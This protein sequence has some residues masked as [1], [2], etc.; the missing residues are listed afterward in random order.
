MSKK[1]YFGGSIITMDQSNPDVQ[2]L[3]VAEGRIVALGSLD[4]CRDALGSGYDEVDLQGRALLPGFFDVHIHPLMAIVFE[5]NVNLHGARDL[6]ELK[7]RFADADGEWLVGLNFDEQ[8][9][10]SKTLPSRVELD[11]ISSDKPVIFVKHDGH[12]VIVNSKILEVCGINAETPDVEGGCI[13]RDEF[14]M[15]TGVLREQAS[16]L[17]LGNLPFPSEEQF[18]VA[19]DATFK[20][21]LSFGIT[22]LGVILQTGE[23]GPAGAVGAFDL[24]M[25]QFLASA[26]PHSFF[27][28]MLSDDVET[29]TALMADSG[30]PDLKIGG[31]KIIADGT[32]GSCTAA[33]REPFSDQS[34]KSGFMLHD[35]DEMYALMSRA[36]RAGLQL[37]IHAIGDKAN[38]SV[39]DLY[40]KL[41]SEQPRDDHRHRIEHASVL[42]QQMI[43]DAKRLGLTMAVQ[44][45]FIHTERPWL[46]NRI[47]AERLKMTYP[48]RSLREAG[49]PLA[50]SSDAPVESQHVMH[51]IQCCVEGLVP[52]QALSLEDA[53]R[54]YTIDAA[55]TLFCEDVRGS[56]SAGK[57]AD[58]VILAADPRTSDKIGEIAVEETIIAG[59]TVFKLG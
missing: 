1:L 46:V 58:M 4:E 31:L 15:P 55:Q 39:I 14:G 8:D 20:R 53:I 52:E 3:A 16:A 29:V 36:H 24:P 19:A 35:S 48:F 26:T 9:L 17:A 41:L 22:S 59:E 7:Q 38:R 32:F 23:D 2:A 5:M 11:Q 49:V 27:G 47:G 54:M 50:G 42:D 30:S 28:Y 45:M 21:M 33:M 6:D 51:A 25:M 40:D 43:D 13:D 34:D 10:T 12:T 18:A 44:P 57:L 56:L 37:S